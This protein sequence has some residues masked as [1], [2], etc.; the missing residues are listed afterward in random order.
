[1]P[2]ELFTGI[3]L[4][5]GGGL[6]YLAYK[7]PKGY[8]LLFS[9][10][11]FSGIGVYLILVFWNFATDRALISLLQILF[12]VDKYQEASEA[13]DKIQIPFKILNISYFIFMSYIT[14]LQYALPKIISADE[15]NEVM[16]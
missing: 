8:S 14:F 4:S 3:L 16:K 11:Y 15:K 9:Y 1:M 7:H 2:S 13:I 10:L 5:I 6:A 12:E